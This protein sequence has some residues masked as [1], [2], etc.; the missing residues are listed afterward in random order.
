MLIRFFCDIMRCF[1]KK[2]NFKK[3]LS[4]VSKLKVSFEI[5]DKQ[6]NRYSV[7]EVFVDVLLLYISSFQYPIFKT[8]AISFSVRCGTWLKASEKSRTISHCLI[9]I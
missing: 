2:Q 7:L 4:E 9:V 8:F 1:I 5:L 6:L 3:N